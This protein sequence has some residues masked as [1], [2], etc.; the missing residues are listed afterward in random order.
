[1]GDTVD[2]VY[3]GDPPVIDEITR[4]MLAEGM[5]HPEA[6]AVLRGAEMHRCTA[7]EGVDKRYVDPEYFGTS[8]QYIFGPSTFVVA[9]EKEDVDKIRGSASGHQWRVVGDPLEDFIL[10]EHTLRVVDEILVGGT[11]DSRMN[12]SD[13]AK[14]F[15]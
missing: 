13:L 10:P 6:A 9:V 7:V 4:F 12:K 11:P 3:V 2:L 15:R 1:M 14:L 5:V 8:K